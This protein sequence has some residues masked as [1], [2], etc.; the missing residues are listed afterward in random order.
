MKIGYFGID[1]SLK[2]DSLI[3]Q[4]NTDNKTSCS[5]SLVK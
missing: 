1:R 5:L 2:R 3:E 4:T